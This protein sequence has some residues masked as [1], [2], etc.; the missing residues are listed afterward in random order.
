MTTTPQQQ[1]RGHPKEIIRGLFGPHRAKMVCRKCHGAFVK[2]V[3]G[4][5][6]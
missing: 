4:N 2:W 1:H 6:L 3:S 5:Q